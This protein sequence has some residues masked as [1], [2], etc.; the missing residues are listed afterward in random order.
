[1]KTKNLIFFLISLMVSCSKSNSDD[2]SLTSK[3]YTVPV[4]LTINGVSRPSKITIT[5][6]QPLGFC[7]EDFILITDTNV[8]YAD[9]FNISMN[10]FKEAGFEFNG[11]EA[12]IGEEETNCDAKE[13]VING[14]ND[15]AY[16]S[17]AVGGGQVTVSG[18]NYTLTCYA[19]DGVPPIDNLTYTITATWTRP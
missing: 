2:D 11:N 17:K 5:D 16:L 1:M 8:S 13:L 3:G 15:T 9:D 6:A 12:T 14:P 7:T 4:E 10:H 19:K 18:K